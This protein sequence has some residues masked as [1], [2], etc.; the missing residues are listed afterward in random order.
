LPAALTIRP[1]SSPPVNRTLPFSYSRGGE[2]FILYPRAVDT[3]TLRLPL[4]R[5]AGYGAGQGDAADAA[6]QTDKAPSGPLTPYLQRYAREVFLRI[7]GQI[8]QDELLAR[9]IQIYREAFDQLVGSLPTSNGESAVAT[10]LS[11]E[12]E[13]PLEET[14]DRWTK[15]ISILGI[16][17]QRQMLGIKDDDGATYLE[18]L[19]KLLGICM[20]EAFDRCV[21][22]ND[23]YETLTMAAI[24]RQLQLLGAEDPLLT[25]FTEGSF[26]ER[27]LRFEI[28]FESKVV[29]QDTSPNAGGTTRLKYRAHVP[30]RFSYGGNLHADA[31]IW[32]GDCNLLPEVA[33]IE[34]PYGLGD[35]TLTVSAGDGT[36][37]AAAAW[38]DV[39]GDS[40]KPVAKLLYNPGEPQAKA[41]LTC[42]EGP[43]DIPI[44]QWAPEYQFL[45]QDET[46]PTQVG[47]GFMARNWVPLRF[48]PGPSQNGEFFAMKPYERGPIPWRPNLTAT[49]ETFI[50]LKHT[51]DAPMPDCS[52]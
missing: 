49:E 34:L 4:V 26:V 41:T 43:I 10:F 11:L 51:P 47:A 16:E 8:S 38:I 15:G 48:G 20:Q 37:T 3:S 33:N 27:C 46:W 35:C 42:D 24:A 52:R 44:L 9:G 25:S 19:I 2:D 23:P 28:D 1:A 31:S 39:L 13:C 18:E 45:H 7:L 21:S 12:E 40:T 29:V 17:K 5:F 14:R 50:F 32:E 36:F 22:R 30:L 6:T